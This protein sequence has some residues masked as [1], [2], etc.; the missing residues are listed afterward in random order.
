MHHDR[1]RTVGRRSMD[2]SLECSAI[3]WDDRGSS[4]EPDAIGT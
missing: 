4:T 1:R 2:E 3:G